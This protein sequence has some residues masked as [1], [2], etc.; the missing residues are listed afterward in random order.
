KQYSEFKFQIL[1]LACYLLQQHGKSET[2]PIEV[3]KDGVNEWGILWK[4]V[5]HALI[6][7]EQEGLIEMVPTFGLPKVRILLGKPF[8]IDE[9]AT[10]EPI[11]PPNAG[12][13]GIL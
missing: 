11:L 6:A 4:Y 2:D 12:T 1:P 3:Q 7:M 10:E 8:A 5:W 13:P 9:L